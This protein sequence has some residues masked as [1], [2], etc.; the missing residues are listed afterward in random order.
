MEAQGRSTDTEIGH[1]SLGE[2]VIPRAFLDDPETHQKLK[3]IFDKH[4]A[5]INEFTVGH[6]DN[7]INPGTGKSE[8]F[9]GGLGSFIGNAYN[10]VVKPLTPILNAGNGFNAVRDSA[11]AL[12]S[13]AGN[14]FLPGSSLLTSQLVSKGAQNT[15]NSPVGQIGQIG[16][17]L[18]GAGVG[19]GTTGIPSAAD[20]GAGWV[21]TGNAIGSAAGYGGLGS[22][23]ASSLGG[24]P[25]SVAG[26]FSPSIG[27]AGGNETF[28]GAGGIAGNIGAAAG[29]GSSFGGGSNSGGILGINGGLGASIASGIG[30]VLNNNALKKAEGTL[31]AG[32]AQQQANLA[33]FNP[34]G[35]TSD[36]GYQFD[37]SQ[38][39]Q[40]LQRQEAASGQT[41]S[42][43]ADKAATEFGQNY[44]D[45]AFQNYYN[46]W[47]N[48]TGASNALIGSNATNQAG[49][50]LQGSQNLGT[51][52]AGVLNPA[53]TQSAALL[54]LLQGRSV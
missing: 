7:K 34:A 31:S 6:D 4:D 10:N 47:A 2:M 8:F 3:D 17:G 5:N 9:F 16:T 35:I 50:G 33:S 43:A 26:N 29:G 44:A 15:L 42:G 38:G 27:S 52:I 18:A 54:K 23:I 20:E 51:S 14:Y 46:R 28:G 49:L 40:A 39:Q 32:N 12:G 1:L 36:P 19:S 13:L 22:S 45:N 53:G 37:L 24:T 48:Q 11:E 41:Q 25:G 21:N 30:G